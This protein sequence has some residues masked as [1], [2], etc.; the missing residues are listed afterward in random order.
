MVILIADDEA[1]IRESI[2]D[3]FKAQH[4]VIHCEDGRAAL[5]VL[6][7]R[8]VDLVI[9]D[10]QMPNISGLDLIRKGKELS[11]NTSYVLMTAHG[12]VAQAVEAI[13]LGAEDYFMKPFELTELRLRV[14]RVEERRA[15]KAEE[16]LKAESPAET[17]IVGKSPA[18]QRA[19][20]FIKKVSAAPSPVLLL[21]PS[22]SGKE[23]LA[24]AIHE[25]G[26]RRNRPFVAI[27]CASL[28]EQLMESELFGHEKGAFTGAT[29]AKPGK[30]ELASQG[31]IFLDEMGE[32]SSQ[33]QAKLLRVLQ[34]KEFY[35]LGGVRQVKTDARVIAAT[36]RPLRDMVKTGAFRED[37]FFRLNVLSFELPPLSKR[38]ED[39]APLI[40]F[41]W[42]RLIREFGCQLRLAP[43]TRQRLCE[44]SFPGNVRELQNLLER[45]VVLGGQE[46]MIGPDAL[47]PEL[48]VF[49]NKVSYSEPAVW[50]GE[51]LNET[52]E[53]LEA[54][55]LRQVMSETGHNQV[56]AAERLKIT[57]GALQYK[58]KKYGIEKPTEEKKAA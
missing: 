11:P 13:H 34:E 36:H 12:S 16:A 20:E 2:A 29:A 26:P 30:F 51:S 5:S 50:Q 49:E 52:L 33:L 53:S 39:I 56:K 15:W 24:K 40:D 10:I 14:D 43:Q 58:L 55:I 54:R 8:T 38:S 6:E 44:Y 25:A 27:N 9:T 45:L 42:G 32:L 7:K 4:E 18:M 46:G 48:N 47:P 31:T 35:R 57:R 37:L 1:G 22:G 17:G 23:V 28:S 3:V 19:R 41:F 21:G